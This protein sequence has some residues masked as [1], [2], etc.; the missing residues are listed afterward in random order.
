MGQTQVNTYISVLYLKYPKTAEDFLNRLPPKK[1]HVLQK[2]SESCNYSFWL[3]SKFLEH[4][5]CACQKLAWSMMSMAWF[6]QDKLGST[7]LLLKGE[8]AGN[9]SGR[10][11]C[12]HWENHDLQICTVFSVCSRCYVLKMLQNLSPSK[13]LLIIV[14][15]KVH[16]ITANLQNL[17]NPEGGLW[18]GE[19]F[20]IQIPK[21]NQ[22]EMFRSYW[23]GWDPTKPP[24]CFLKTL[25]Q[26]NAQLLLT[27]SLTIH[28]HTMI[29][30]NGN[31]MQ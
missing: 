22:N 17:K 5:I 28:Q 9:L 3:P 11:H 2:S 10:V 14:A 6:K 31:N 27:M 30:I 12:T 18:S 8:T 7:D 15:S 26:R 1:K 16:Y 29:T 24:L 4:L 13:F 20:D 25:Q 23:Q 19:G 21:M